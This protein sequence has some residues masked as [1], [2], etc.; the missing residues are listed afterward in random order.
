MDL[1]LD[2]DFA[3][4]VAQIADYYSWETFVECF[5]RRDLLLA[6]QCSNLVEFEFVV[7]VVAVAVAA[8][9]WFESSR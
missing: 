4:Q 7:P 1:H 3:G 8:V 5:Q 9:H 2:S 6:I